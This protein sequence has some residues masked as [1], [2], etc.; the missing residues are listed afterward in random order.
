MRRVPG[1]LRAAVL[2]GEVFVSDTNSGLWIV[3]IEGDDEE[4][5][6]GL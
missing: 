3:E 1:G 5:Q 2:K 4:K 6:P